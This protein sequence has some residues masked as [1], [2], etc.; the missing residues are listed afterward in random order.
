[1]GSKFETCG[2]GVYEKTSR[3]NWSL[4]GCSQRIREGNRVDWI[5]R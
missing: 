2:N 3:V 5:L 1:M 4:A